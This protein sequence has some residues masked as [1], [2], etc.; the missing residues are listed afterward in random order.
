MEQSVVPVKADSPIWADQLGQRA[1]EVPPR[2][3]MS[4]ADRP[5][6]VPPLAPFAIAT[7]SDWHA[8]LRSLQANLKEL[9]RAKRRA[10]FRARFADRLMRRV[11]S[12][13]FARRTGAAEDSNS[14]IETQGSVALDV[15]DQESRAQSIRV[16]EEL[17]LADM[18]KLVHIHPDPIMQVEWAAR[19]DRFAE[20]LAHAD[21]GS[22]GMG[23]D[24]ATLDLETRRESIFFDIAKGFGLLVLTPVALALAALF[25]AGAIL[26]GVGKLISGLGHLLTLGRFR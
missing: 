6:G 24:L 26:Y 20:A 14:D 11:R 12:T 8:T 2:Y 3:S 9:H 21:S 16:L 13:V 7:E 15:V 25:G 4:S 10:R 23:Y 1:A 18:R 17:V 5:A 22:A 19:S